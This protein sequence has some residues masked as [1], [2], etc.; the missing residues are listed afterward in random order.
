[1]TIRRCGRSAFSPRRSGASSP[2]A[3]NSTPD[4]RRSIARS[5]RTPWCCST[6]S[7]WKLGLNRRNIADSQRWQAGINYRQLARPDRVHDLLRSYGVTHLVWRRDVAPNPHREIPA[8]SELVL[9]GYALRYGEDR[10]EVA[11][12][13]VARLPAQR[14]PPRE[15]GL[16]DLRGLQRRARG[17]A[18]RSGSRRHRRGGGWPRRG[19]RPAG[20]A[21]R[22]RIRGG[23]PPLPGATFRRCVRR[24]ARR[25]AGAT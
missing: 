18:R 8:A 17:R 24:S 25:R 10:R 3:G 15:P 12:Y 16:G 5:P 13:S 21:H 11:E 20:H 7:T 23:R 2:P 19:R 22:R 6:R 9:F 14:P 4:S 1:M